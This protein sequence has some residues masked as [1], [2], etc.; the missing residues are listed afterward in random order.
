MGVIDKKSSQAGNGTYYESEESGKWKETPQGRVRF[1]VSNNESVYDENIR[2]FVTTVRQ[3][4]EPA[5]G[6]ISI[7]AEGEKLVD[8]QK[9]KK[10]GI[11]GSGY[12]ISEKAAA[13]KAAAEKWKLS[14]REVEIVKS[15]R[16]R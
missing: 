5:I 4:N 12:L 11:F 9:E 7:Y 13:E 15:L 16:N 14:E 2:S 8:A 6:K 3:D 10:Q 1:I